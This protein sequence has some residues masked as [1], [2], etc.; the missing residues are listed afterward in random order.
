MAI[1]CKVQLT[2]WKNLPT[3]TE[4]VL[5]ETIRPLVF[6]S[7]IFCYYIIQWD[8][9]IYMIYIHK[10][11]RFYIV[12]R[13]L[14]TSEASWLS[15][16][17]KCNIVELRISDRVTAGPKPYHVFAHIFPKCFRKNC[18]I[19][20][21]QITMLIKTVFNFKMSTAGLSS[22][23]KSNNCSLAGLIGATH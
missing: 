17:C 22:A 14:M 15:T 5:G 18:Q 23:L 8:L 2:C 3:T 12:L 7:S 19:R 6:G 16:M 21:Q 9:K 10:L 1:C 13:L 11:N 20:A 4:Y